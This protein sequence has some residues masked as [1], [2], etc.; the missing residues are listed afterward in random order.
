MYADIIGILKVVALL[1]YR[2]VDSS[3]PD[4]GVSVALYFRNFGCEKREKYR[5]LRR[6]RN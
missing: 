5:Q 6:L 3:R 2:F 4:N 1:S